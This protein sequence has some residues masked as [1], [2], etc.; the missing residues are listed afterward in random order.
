MNS[1]SNLWENRFSSKGRVDITV[2]FINIFLLIC[3][4]FLMIV[5][6]FANHTFMIIMNCISITIYTI[7]IFNCYKNIDRYFAILFINV[8]LHMICA[9]ISFGWTPCFQNWSFALIA[10]FFLPVFNSEN[11][12]K[13]HLKSFILAF[14]VILTYM[15]FSVL[16]N[17]IDFKIFNPLSNFL[18]RL[19]FLFNNLMSF[20]S[21]M[22]LALFFTRTSIRRER[23]LSRK[24]DFDELTNIYNRHALNEMSE[25]IIEIAKEHK[26]SY[27]VAILDIDHFKKIN[28][29]YGHSNGDIVLKDLANIIKNHFSKSY[30]IGRWG[31]E[32]FVIFS[33]PNIRYNEF[34]SNLEKLRK[35]VENHPFKFDEKT[36]KVT[37]S[38]G[39]SITKDCKPLDEAVVNADINLYKAKESGRNKLVS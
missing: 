6:S 38:I 26:K 21:I 23:E 2:F 37:I 16:I 15:I 28:D 14:G 27:N 34:T 8:W 1:L 32:E 31:G 18:N 12:N 33:Y 9:I 17:V 22:M 3:N 30:I 10:A 20:F 7:S 24:A 13:S 11:T 35:K 36:I 39:A 29:K 25:K 4:I 5:Y 19:L